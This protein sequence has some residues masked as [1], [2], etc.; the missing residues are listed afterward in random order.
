M[1]V[2]DKVCKQC[3]HLTVEDKCEKCG[4]NQFL[5]KYKGKIAVFDAKRSELAEKLEIESNGRFAL[6]YN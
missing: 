6:K 2:K 4:S 3:G 5:E 1:A